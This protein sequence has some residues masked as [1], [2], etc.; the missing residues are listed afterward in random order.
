MAKMAKENGKVSGKTAFKASR[1]GDLAAQK[2]VSDYIKHLAEGI[3][4]MINLLAPKCVLLGG[5]V[6][7]EGDN[8]LNP[9]REAVKPLVYGGNRVQRA[10]IDV[11]KL[12][13]D[14]GIIGAAM[15]GK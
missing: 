13:N 3:A 2:V 12:G 9:L 11:A 8:L 14:A 6:S 15:L 10:K 7:H 1:E 5:G 4:N